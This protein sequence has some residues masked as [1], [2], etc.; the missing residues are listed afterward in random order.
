MPEQMHREGFSLLEVLVATTLMGLILVVLLQVLTATLRAQSAAWENTQAVLVADK[1]LQENCQINSLAG[2]TFQ[3]RVG[4]Y[5]YQV[6]I[7]PQFELTSPFSDRRVLCSIVQVTVSWQE[8]GQA[9][10]LSLQT[11]RTGVQKK[12]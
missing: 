10:T 9:K 1:I 5:A 2:G 4:P 11:V 12:S 7:T 3:G 8:W 6:Q